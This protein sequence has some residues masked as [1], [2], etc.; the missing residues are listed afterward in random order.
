LPAPWSTTIIGLVDAEQLTEMLRRHGALDAGHVTAVT[1][2]DSGAFASQTSFL[3]VTYSAD[4]PPGAPTA[5]VLKRSLSSAWGQAAGADE[6]RFYDT[7]RSTVGHPDVIVPCYATGF[8]DGQW[9]VLLADMSASHRPPVT[10]DQQIG[11][12]EGV[13]AAHHLDQVLRVLARLHAFWWNRSGP[14]FETSHWY[15][16][17]GQFARYLERRGAAWLSVTATHDLPDVY[18]RALDAL[19]AYWET[20][21]RPRFDPSRNV[22]LTHGDTYFANFLCSSSPGDDAFLIDWQSA[23][24]DLCGMDLANLLATF[25]TREQRH[26]QQRELRA[27]RRYHELLDVPAFAWEDLLTDYRHG[28]IYWLLVPLQDAADGSVESYWRPK[29]RCLIEAFE[30]HHCA[31]LLFD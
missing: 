17:A 2:R 3:S 30:D 31:E 22:T 7:I 21:V 13:P 9:F 8:D 1:E 29:M 24:F 26:D 5:L 12:V 28:I 27:L 20:W 18:R 14:A 6:V 10:R 15:R 19:P 23:E 11:I 16:D 25:W 4:A